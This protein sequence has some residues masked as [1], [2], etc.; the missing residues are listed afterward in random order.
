MPLMDIS[1][2]VSRIISRYG[3]KPQKIFGQNF[4]TDSALLK[5]MIDYARVCSD[6]VV[7][8][9]GAGL[10]FLTELLSEKAGKVIAVEKDSNLMRILKDRLG[11]KENIVLIE[12]DIMKTRDLIFDKVVSNPPYQLSSPLLFKLLEHGFKVMVL[13]FQREFAR[14][15]IAKEGTK[16]YG[17]LS[18]MA[19]LKS[20]SEILEYVNHAVFSPSPRVESAVVRL[21]PEGPSLQPL[22]V[23]LFSLFVRELFTQR[24]KTSKKVIK[25]FIKKNLMLDESGLNTLIEKLPYLGKRV[26]QISPSEFIEL[27]NMIYVVKRNLAEDL[28]Q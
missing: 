9:I 24:N 19:H 26:Y 23:S 8:E 1:D 16:E 17:R 13:T 7:L 20:R 21:N 2:D 6:D 15:L 10:G 3:I 25:E 4:V 28:V 5:R 27:S 18:V 12:K 22:D 14:R 11:N